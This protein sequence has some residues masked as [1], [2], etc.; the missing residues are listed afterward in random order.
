MTFHSVRVTNKPQ[1]A[2]NAAYNFPG[3]HCSYSP[4]PILV[5]MGCSDVSDFEHIY[6]QIF[7]TPSCV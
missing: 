4:R 3:T 6:G 1:S 7:T 2:S 5:Y